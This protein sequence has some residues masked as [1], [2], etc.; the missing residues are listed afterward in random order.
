MAPQTPFVALI[1]VTNHLTFKDI[2]GEKTP[3]SM[4]VEVI[5]KYKG[6]E[7]RKTVTVWGDPGNLCRPYLSQFTEGQYYVIAFNNAGR[8]K[9]ETTT[10]YSISICGCYWLQADH[11]KQTA[12]G[13]ISIG[14]LF[15]K[16]TMDLSQ[17]KLELKKT[18]GTT[19]P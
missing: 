12:T 2:Y 9:D 14:E 18:D 10:D 8:G 4:E 13:D 15:A 7:E 17:I 6:S 3:M 16:Q 1:K 19:L 5:E 11:E